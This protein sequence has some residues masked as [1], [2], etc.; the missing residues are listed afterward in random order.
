VRQEFLKKPAF[1]VVDSTEQ[2]LTFR[3][4]FAAQA[5]Q[6]L[7]ATGSGKFASKEDLAKSAY[8]YADAMLSKR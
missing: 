4:Y 1:P 2:G 5:M 8:E 3:D 7:I 6:S